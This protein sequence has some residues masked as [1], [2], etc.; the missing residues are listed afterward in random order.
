LDQKD[1]NLHFK[2]SNGKTIYYLLAH[3]FANDKN[4]F[5]LFKKLLKKVGNKENIINEQDNFNQTVVCYYL[6]EFISNVGRVLNNKVDQEM[7]QMRKEIRER[8]QL[9]RNVENITLS[10]EE[11]EQCY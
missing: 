1:L 6:S 11:V 4:A 7:Q 3:H 5:A 2:D 9:S 8:K 10:K